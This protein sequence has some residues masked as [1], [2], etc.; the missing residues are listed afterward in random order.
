MA[1]AAVDAVGGPVGLVSVVAGLV[2]GELGVGQGDLLL[3]GEA[4][5]L[6]KDLGMPRK[7]AVPLDGMRP[8][9]LGGAKLVLVVGSQP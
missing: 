7:R 1:V 3:Q 8:G 4:L 9:E 5:R 2:A 6:A